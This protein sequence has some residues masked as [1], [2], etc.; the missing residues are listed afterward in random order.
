MDSCC[1]LN[2]VPP[3]L[4]GDGGEGGGDI[5]H[6]E[7]AW[8]N[9]WQNSYCHLWNGK[10]NEPWLG[11]LRYLFKHVVWMLSLQPK[12]E[13]A[14]LLPVPETVLRTVGSRAQLQVHARPWVPWYHG[15]GWTPGEW[16]RR[17]ASQW[18]SRCTN[19]DDMERLERRRQEEAEVK[20]RVQSFTFGTKGAFSIHWLGSSL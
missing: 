20:R 13:A 16:L 4:G 12:V 7:C 14:L 10:D 15:P 18:R 2:Q 17:T 9:R 19:V 6:P 3:V 5:L 11:L 1:N 8:P